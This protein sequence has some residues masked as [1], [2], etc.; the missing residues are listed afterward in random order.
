MIFLMFMITQLFS[1]SPEPPNVAAERLVLLFHI[2]EFCDSNLGPETALSDLRFCGFFSSSSKWWYILN[3]A[4]TAS[5]Y[6]VSNSL[7][8]NNLPMRCCVI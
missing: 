4:T 2:R 8:I 7:F 6:I 3:E 5:F 1:L